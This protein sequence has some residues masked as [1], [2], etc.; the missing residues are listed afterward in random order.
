[1]IE[2]V[3]KDERDVLV[4]ALK[5]RRYCATGDK[6]DIMVGEIEFD[7]VSLS[8][9]ARPEAPVTI[10]APSLFYSSSILALRSSITSL[11]RFLLGKPSL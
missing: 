5:G 1:M 11:G 8:Y 6:P 10:S 7:G 9:P 2:R 4:L 3:K